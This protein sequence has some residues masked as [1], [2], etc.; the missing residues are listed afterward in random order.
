MKSI[1]FIVSLIVTNFAYAQ[2]APGA[3]QAGSTAI[4][5]DSSIIV[6]WAN[7]CSVLRGYINIEDTTQTFTQDN[8]TLN[9]AFFGESD[10]AIGVAKGSMDVVSLGDGGSAVLSF[11]KPI[12]NGEGPDFVV[13]EN[14]MKSQAPPYNYF[15]EL[16]FVEV[17]TN[18][19]DYVRFPSVSLTQTNSQVAG[20]GQL[21]PTKI[22]NLAGKYEACY[23]TPFDLNDIADSANINIDSILFVKIIDVVGSVNPEYAGYDSQGNIINDPFTTPYWTGGFDLDAVGVINQKMIN[24]VALINNAKKVSIYPN[25]TSSHVNLQYNSNNITVKNIEVYDATGKKICHYT[26]VDMGCTTI[27]DISSLKRGIY[28]LKISINDYFIT[29]KV[30]KN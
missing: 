30:I 28:I 11:N 12:Y 25:P 9:R 7:S 16:A 26:V 23:G 3:G 27:L 8:I 24:L 22:Y 18:G 15:L 10:D 5:K 21:N 29:K 19:V 17:S 6:G 13:F 1:L 4:Y 14:G 2:Y 20:F